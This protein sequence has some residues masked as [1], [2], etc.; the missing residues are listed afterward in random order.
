MPTPR[1]PSAETDRRTTP[2]RR[3]TRVGLPPVP[4]GWGTYATLVAFG[5][6]VSLTGYFATDKQ[7]EESNRERVTL[8][9]RASSDADSAQ[10]RRD[11]S[12]IAGRAA[13]GGGRRRPRT[14]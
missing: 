7:E 9:A 14:T 2:A 8:A 6:A 13:C 5:A 4:G 1:D 12:A 3:A 11:S 10:R